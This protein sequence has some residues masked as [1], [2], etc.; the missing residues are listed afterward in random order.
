MRGFWVTLLVCG[1]SAPALAQTTVSGKV[2]FEGTAPAPEPVTVKSDIATCGAAKE[3][4]KI[5]VEPDGGVANA[6]V[7][8]IGIPGAAPKSGGALDQVRCEFVPHV[9]AVGAGSVLTITSSDPVL[10]NAHGFYEDGSTAFNVAVP[11]AGMEIPVTMKQPGV[12]KLRCD[13]GHTWMSA[14]VLVMDHPFYAV[15]AA[16]G[17]FEISGVPPG[18]YELE[19]WHEWLGRQRQQVVVSE[20]TAAPTTVVLKTPST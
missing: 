16:D 8:L 1:L 6:V 9:Q 4:H 11:I 10:H 14:Y 13:A 12:L 15:T 17:R 3:V 18:T 20:S 2:V 19:V 5:L 7:Q